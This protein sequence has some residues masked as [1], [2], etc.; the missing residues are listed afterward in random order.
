MSMFLC[1]I[2][3][4]LGCC[5]SALS[6]TFELVACFLDGIYI[7]KCKV[8]CCEYLDCFTASEMNAES[9]LCRGKFSDYSLTE[10]SSLSLILPKIKEENERM[11]DILHLLS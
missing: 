1:P 10:A 7:R 11:L 6:K 8:E 3:L 5:K 2:G 9:L 4:Q